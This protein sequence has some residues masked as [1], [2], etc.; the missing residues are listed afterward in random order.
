MARPIKKG[1]DYFSFDT[2]FFTN[3]TKIKKL[4]LKYNSL[5]I[6]VY[7]YLITQAYKEFGYY[8]IYDEDLLIDIIDLFKCQEKEVIN[9]IKFLID[10]NLFTEFEIT[11]GI[12]ILTSERIQKTYQASVKVRGNKTPVVVN[13]RIW[14][15]PKE[16]LPDYMK[17]E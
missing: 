9:I 6:I 10:V 13:K 1:I 2:D 16:Q 17:L 15:L 4:R 12:K 7:I 5:G 8:L 3:D 14:A 11:S